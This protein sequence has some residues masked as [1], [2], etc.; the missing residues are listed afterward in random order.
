MKRIETIRL[1]PTIAQTAALDHAL[2]VTR[3]LYNALLQERR[4]AWRL[5]KVCL[6]AKMQYAEL[7]DLRAESIHLRSVYRECEDAVLRRLDIAYAAAFSR[8]KR[9]EKAGFPR[10]KGFARFRQI[11]FPHG[12]RCIKLDAD[13]RRVRIPGVGSVKL[14][15]GRIIPPFKRVWIVRKNDRW[16][17][18]FECDRSVE[19]LPATHAHIGLDRGVTVLLATSDGA[20]IENPAFFKT[21]RLRLERAQRV[22]AKR[23]KNGRNRRKAIIKLA[24]IHETIKNQRRDHAHKESR[25]IVNAYDVIALEDLNLRTMTRSAKGTIASPGRNVAAKSGLNRALLDAGFGQ[26]A[27]LIAEKAES[28]AR[29]IIHVDPRYTSQTCSKCDHV[30]SENRHGIGFLCVACGHTEHADV[31]A[32]KNILK[33]AQKEPSASRASLEDGDDPSTALSSSGPRLTL[34]EAA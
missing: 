18:Q 17:A 30:A 16:Y 9:G 29:T 27:R 3:H 8:M 33:L 10:F 23:K 22:V 6:T 15:K 19:P 21:S 5:R 12:D 20:L 13:Q 34:H 24:R 28:A 4:D 7:T 32:A 2:H 11:T 25:R 26:I 1:Y 14:R 31:N